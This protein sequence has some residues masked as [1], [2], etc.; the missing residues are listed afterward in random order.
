MLSFAQCCW[1][2]L[3]CCCVRAQAVFERARHE[4]GSFDTP[5]IFNVVLQAL[6][7]MKLPSLCPERRW[8]QQ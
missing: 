1:S 8:K 4:L 7:K 6:R 5:V 2:L 3:L